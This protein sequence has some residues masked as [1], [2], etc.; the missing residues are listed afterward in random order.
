MLGG[1][2][3]TWMMSERLALLTHVTGGVMKRGWS[4]SLFCFLVSVVLERIVGV[5]SYRS[6]KTSRRG[7]SPKLV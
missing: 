1:S 7:K 4:A 6:G 3:D 2:R 5:V